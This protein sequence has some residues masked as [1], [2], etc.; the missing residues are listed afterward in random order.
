ML[1]TLLSAKQDLIL[2]LEKPLK[3]VDGYIEGM[4]FVTHL[5]LDE[6]NGVIDFLI[7]HQNVLASLHILLMLDLVLYNLFHRVKIHAYLCRVSIKLAFSV[8]LHLFFLLLF[9]LVKVP[10]PLFVC[11]WQVLLILAR[12]TF[13]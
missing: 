2:L 12:Q 10:L 3:S 7:E 13:K 5:I 1:V 9:E 6:N 11:L 4:V 8:L